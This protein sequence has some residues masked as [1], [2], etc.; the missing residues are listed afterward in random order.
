MTE[1]DVFKELLKEEWSEFRWA[2]GSDN[3][4]GFETLEEIEA[5]D[6][7]WGTYMDVIT[8]GPSGQLYKWSYFSGA[9]EM[10][11]NERMDE[12]VVPVVAVEKQITITEYKEIK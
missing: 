7:R 6:S 10:Q 9:T 12:D 5:G 2:D 4:D 3:Y 11:E 1:L 8:K